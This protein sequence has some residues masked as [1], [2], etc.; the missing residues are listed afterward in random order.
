M[1][2]QLTLGRVYPERTPIPAATPVC[3]RF[4]AFGTYRA[5]P[6]NALSMRLTDALGEE[7]EVRNIGADA[8]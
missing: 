2:D 7:L 5:Q 1:V 6:N 4:T 3:N 8:G